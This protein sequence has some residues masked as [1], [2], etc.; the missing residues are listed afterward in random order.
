[1]KCLNFFSLINQMILHH[2]F[3]KKLHTFLIVFSTSLKL[4]TYV[5]FIFYIFFF[6]I[7]IFKFIIIA[8]LHEFFNFIIIYYFVIVNK[9]IEFYKL[10]FN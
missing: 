4:I 10:N 7:I 8:F 3:L 1:M 2:K 5:N 9:L 6:L